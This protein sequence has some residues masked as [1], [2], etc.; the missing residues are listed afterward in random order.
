MKGAS[1]IKVQQNC[2]PRTYKKGG[3]VGG[4]NP[5]LS[6]CF[7]KFGLYV[8]IL[9]T[10]DRETCWNIKENLSGE[11]RNK[12]VLTSNDKNYFF[13]LSATLKEIRAEEEKQ[14]DCIFLFSSARK[15]YIHLV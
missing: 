10:F 11:K 1:N 14:V 6:F 5:L 2:D 9:G 3:E 7:N 12:Y 13:I 8:C 4:W 15:I